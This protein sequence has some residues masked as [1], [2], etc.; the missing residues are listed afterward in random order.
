MEG[1]RPSGR[2]EKTWEVI[3][4]DCQMQQI[5][6]EDAMDCRK[7]RKLIKDVV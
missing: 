1:V 6:Q 3:E 5:C 2:P 7:W 4:N